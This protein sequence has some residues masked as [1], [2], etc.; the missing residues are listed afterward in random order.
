MSEHITCAACG[1]KYKWKPE[2]VGKTVK[3]KCGEMIAVPVMREGPPLAA[4]ADEAQPAAKRVV[5][6][7]NAAMYADRVPKRYS[8]EEEPKKS[9]GGL[10]AGVLAI[11]A[12]AGLS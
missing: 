11:V 3:C 2:L 4:L 6:P 8:A 1:A 5:T 7:S 9:K 10:I 12:V